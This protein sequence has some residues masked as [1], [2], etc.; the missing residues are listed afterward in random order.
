[1][2]IMIGGFGRIGKAQ[3]PPDRKPGSY[4]EGN[5]LRL[6]RGCLLIAFAINSFHVLILKSP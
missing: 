6:R 5:K 2:V 1:L 3:R 4:P